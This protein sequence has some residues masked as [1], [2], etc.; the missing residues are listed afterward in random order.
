MCCRWHAAGGCSGGTAGEWLH[1]ALL[2]AGGQAGATNT[3][4]W[5]PPHAHAQVR[6]GNGNFTK[7]Y[8]KFH[9]VRLTK[10]A[11]YFYMPPGA[12][13]GLSKLIVSP[14]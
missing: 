9:N 12:L 2:E 11:M 5:L 14:G 13:D 10:K 3:P 1:W 6:N 4:L 7:F 8:Y